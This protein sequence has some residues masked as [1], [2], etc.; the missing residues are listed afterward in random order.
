ML[1]LHE[2]L[3][4]EDKKLFNLDIKELSWEEYFITLTQGVRV[5]LSKEPLTNLSKARSK[6]TT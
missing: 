5:Y 4:S 3:S 2:T 6:D 1:E